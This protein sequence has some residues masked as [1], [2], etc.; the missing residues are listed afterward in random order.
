MQCA[1]SVGDAFTK[2]ALAV[3]TV[4]AQGF[5]LRRPLMSERVGAGRIHKHAVVEWGVLIVW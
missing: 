4:G 3:R 5:Q 1:G 2:A